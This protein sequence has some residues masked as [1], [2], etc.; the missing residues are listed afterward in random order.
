MYERNIEVRSSNHCCR[1]KAVSIIYS[2]CAFVALEIQHAK[3]TRRIILSSVFYL[4][5]QLLPHYLKSGTIFGKK[6][7][8]HKMCVLIFITTFVLHISHYKK[9]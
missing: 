2:E 7:I 5:L 4:A 8:E 6:V 1:G 3:R 9:K